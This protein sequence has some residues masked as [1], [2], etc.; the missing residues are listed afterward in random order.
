M[1]FLIS[2]AFI[3][4]VQI[5]FAQTNYWA[6]SDEL[7]LRN[8]QTN[9]VVKPRKYS[10][11]KFNFTKFKEETQLNKNKSRES[12]IWIFPMPDG[13]TQSFKVKEASIFE[14]GLS[15]K[16]P[17][18]TSYTGMGIENPGAY[19]KMSISPF[20]IHVM[21]LTESANSIFIDPYT[22]DSSD[23]YIVYF[24]NDY[25]KPIAFTGFKCG[26]GEEHGLESELHFPDE[27]KE[28]GDRSDMPGDCMMRSYRLALA[29]TGEYA[30]YH[31][32]TVEKVLAAYNTAMTRVNGV[33]EKELSITM[34]LVEKTDTLIFLNAS[35]DPY[36]NSNGS[37]MLTQNQTTINAR[38]G[39][40]NYDIGHVFSTGGG[41]IASL[42]SPCT[43][44]K[45]QGVTGSAAP[46]GDPFTI[47][48]VAHEMG[49]QFGANHTQNNNCQRNNS[50][51]MEPGSA[52]TIMGY[53][54]ICNPNV[55][56]NSHAYFHAISLSEIGAFTATGSGR[57]C[58]TIV[59]RE[60]NKPN[61][62]VPRSNY[63]LPISTAF[64]LRANGTDADGDAL[65]YCWEQV[66]NAAAT[67]P[68]VST[69]A[70]GPAFRS[71]PP[72]SNPIRYFPDLLRRYNTW[73]VL[74]S[75]TRVMRFRCT[76]RDNNPLG[77]CT[78]EANVQI[79][80]NNAAG[81]FVV[82]Y[83]NVSSVN[84]KVGSTQKVTWNVASTNNAPINCAMVD[85]LLS[86]DGGATYPDTLV[87]GVPNT[88]EYDIFVPNRPTTRARIMVV[89]NDNIF[90][91]VSNA[92]FR[93]TSSFNAVPSPEKI[94][95]CN[96][97]SKSID[98][99]VTKSVAADILVQ[100]EMDASL[101]PQ[102]FQFSE[103]PVTAP[104]TSVLNI[105][106]L[107]NLPTG[108][109]QLNIT[110][111]TLDEKIIFPVFL[112]KGAKVIPDVDAI[113]PQNNQKGINSA[114]VVF[115]WTTFEGVNEYE[116]QISDN[117]IFQNIL[118][119]ATVESNNATFQLDNL[120]V[121]YWRVRGKSP[122]GFGSYSDT[123][124]FQ[125]GNPGSPVIINNN[126]LLINPGEMAIINR[127]LLDVQSSDPE[128]TR[129]L[130]TK[131][132]GNGTLILDGQILPYAGSTFTLSE[133]YS[134]KLIYFNDGNSDETDSF[135]FS[136]IDDQER[137]SPNNT[138][139]IRIRQANL[140]AVAFLKKIITCSDTKDGHI[141]AD[142][143]GGT[144][145]YTF[146]ADGLT[147]QD[148][149]DFDTLTA[150]TYSITIKDSNGEIF[151]S[152]SITL[153]QPPLLTLNVFT[154]GYNIRATAAGGVGT[155]EYSLNGTN[156]GA[157]NLYLDPGNGD[158]LVTVTD[159][160][161]CVRS[162]EISLN[163][164]ELI[165][166][167]QVENIVCSGQKGKVTINME[168]GIP[169]YVY[170]LG[171]G[172]FQANKVFNLDAG[173]Y[174]FSTRDA[175]G[176][177]ILS[178][179]IILTNPEPISV[180]TTIDR[181]LLTVNASGGS[182]ALNYSIDGEIY[183]TKDSFL[184]DENGKYTVFV[185][186]EVG[187][188]VS[189]DFE[190]SVLKSAVYTITN[191]SCIGNADGKLQITPENGKPPFSFHLQS[192]PD[193]IFT[194]ENGIFNDLAP[195]LYM[196]TITDDNQDSI[197][198]TLWI[199]EPDSLTLTI[200]VE[201]NQ[202]TLL[203]FGG[204]PPYNYSLDNGISFFP[205]NIFSELPDTTYFLQVVDQKGCTIS[206]TVS[207]K[208]TSVDEYSEEN[209][210]LIF[211]NPGQGIFNLKKNDYTD[212]KGN[213]TIS[214]ILGRV[215][216]S[217]NFGTPDDNEILVNLENFQD[218]KYLLRYIEGNKYHQSILVKISLH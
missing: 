194:S 48:F 176:K 141:F 174:V 201:D 29:C 105:S 40:N 14:P 107:Q 83:P 215:V 21:I 33:Y 55:Q 128:N 197:M 168:G 61:V 198:D 139:N 186:D 53:A 45:A 3:L 80:F 102:N 79:N 146:S 88:G 32:G 85:I 130:I 148:S 164:P 5:L 162:S 27:L 150:G 178:D 133:I 75:V 195:G 68:P 123:R 161:G 131:Y 90:Y 31:G 159:K 34:K 179:S 203:P 142:G 120:K 6:P 47:D 182:G 56:N 160:N 165:I 166:T 50:T 116:I 173:T 188:V 99:N 138:F 65:T 17:G 119:S 76:V 213:L 144:A 117:P 94:N 67:M 92:N 114:N 93:I 218:G 183:D 74:P 152:N 113:S 64:Y 212:F 196:L 187:C 10:V 23:D 118:Q 112:Y 71:L 86:T 214:D 87:T 204:T 12:A 180:Q 121:Y 26:V 200:I 82:T 66:D 25:E 158:Y 216:Y 54:G 22:P 69:S 16:Y 175:G 104:G 199:L 46:V 8:E 143:F 42:G 96:E 60:N 11:L 101:P 4:C 126:L 7:S 106:N 36:T 24:K 59:D 38:I 73:E 207:I 97:T 77:G 124:A 100:L 91:D 137:W 72:T 140:H 167:P 62:T 171:T 19:L 35:T 122:C 181:N 103:N 132:T 134:E 63:V 136:V 78:H 70:V 169:P 145:P 177:I 211:P 81:P 193:T 135:E 13:T 209:V 157:Q 1:R 43:S 192:N 98:I 58:A 125:T 190:I 205:F 172:N 206:D 149:P 57:T 111:T 170:K 202:I 154:Q 163:I 109:T 184:F 217:N 108:T 84:W 51:S 20:N 153:A 28:N 89:A 110:A 39:T 2:T 95:F 147:F 189:F 155:L 127:N 191:V 15:Q 44:R 9:R 37:A 151:I 115:E 30:Q 49:H 210:L 208:F 41:G 185:K 18:F 129:F 156:V 52:S